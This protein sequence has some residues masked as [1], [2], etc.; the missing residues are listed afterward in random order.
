MMVFQACC[1][2]NAVIDNKRQSSM[3]CPEVSVSILSE[4]VITTYLSNSLAA[5]NMATSNIFPVSCPPLK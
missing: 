3:G 4:Y 2:E 5:V 1:M